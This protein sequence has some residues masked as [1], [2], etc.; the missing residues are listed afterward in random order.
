MQHSEGMHHHQHQQYLDQ[1]QHREVRPVATGGS[2]GSY[3]P[4][5]NGQIQRDRKIIHAVI[6]KG[7]KNLTDLT[8]PTKKSGYGPGS[9]CMASSFHIT[10]QAIINAV[11]VSLFVAFTSTPTP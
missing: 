8:P 7:P 11:T 6:I 4:P 1:L 5:Q 10:L 3:D 2:G 9:T